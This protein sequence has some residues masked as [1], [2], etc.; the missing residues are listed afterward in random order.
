MRQVYEVFERFPDGSTLWRACVIG[1]FEA[2]RRM[3]ELEEHSENGFFL[4]DVPAEDV[5]PAPSAPKST[6]PLLKSAV[7]G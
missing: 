1:R 6:V 5:L 7:A 3:Q 2:R 4:I